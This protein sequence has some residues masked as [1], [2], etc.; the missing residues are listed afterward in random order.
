MTQHVTIQ[1]D[2]TEIERA[3]EAAEAQGVSTE[4][5]LRQLI[6]ANLPLGG[7][8]VKRA[9]STMFPLGSS[10]GPTDISKEKDDMISEAVWDEYLRESGQK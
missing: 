4:E 8:P 1:L 5:F 10:D 7:G 6:A 9:F 3:R 2:E